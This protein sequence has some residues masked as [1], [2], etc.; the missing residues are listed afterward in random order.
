M[1]PVNVQGAGPGVHPADSDPIFGLLGLLVF[2]FNAQPPPLMNGT[3]NRARDVVQF[4][5][6][7]GLLRQAPVFQRGQAEL[8]VER[9][10]KA[11]LALVADPGGDV[12]H[13]LGGRAQQLGGSFEP[14][15]AEVAA[16]SR[17]KSDEAEEESEDAAKEPAAEER[18]A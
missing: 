14:A 4:S 1:Q 5:A 10:G 9:L 11:A 7:F 17:K 2:V 18:A 16:P 6:P 13:P 3:E 12:L 8:V 15:A